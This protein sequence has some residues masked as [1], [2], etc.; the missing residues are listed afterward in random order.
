MKVTIGKFARRGI[1]DQLGPD[2]HA[3]FLAALAHYMRRLKS[4]W[5][6]IRPPA[7]FCPEPGD[8]EDSLELTLEAETEAALEREAA[9]HQVPV[10]QILTHAVL[11]YLADMDA[12][13]DDEPLEVASPVTG[14]SPTGSFESSPLFND[15]A[16]ELRRRPALR[17]AP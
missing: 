16:R 13:M 6:P 10:D 3:G 2:L 5:A 17:P 12:A 9:R 15:S 11:V 8:A 7:F 14:T 4:E 1:E